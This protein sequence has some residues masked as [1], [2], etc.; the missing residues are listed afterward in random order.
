M[1]ALNDSNVLIRSAQ[2]T[3]RHALEELAQL[4]S[5]RYAGQPALVAEID[6]EIE[7]AVSIDGGLSIADPFRPTGELVALLELAAHT[8]RT[9]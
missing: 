1:H 4:D 7:A 6:G 5:N 8:G 2:D 3:D 9:N